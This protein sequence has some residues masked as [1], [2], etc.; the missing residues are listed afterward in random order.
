[1]DLQVS[2]TRSRLAIVHARCQ[3]GFTL[4]ELAVSTA[5]AAV[6]IGVAA[7]LATATLGQSGGGAGGQ[8]S[9]V[10]STFSRE[11]IDLAIRG[12]YL[13]NLRLPCVDQTGDGLENCDAASAA[14][15]LPHRTLGLNP[16]PQSTWRV[17]I[18]YGVYRNAPTADLAESGNRYALR[19]LRYGAACGAATPAGACTVGE[20]V[21]IA[22]GVSF[23][24]QTDSTN[25]MRDVCERLGVAAAAAQNDGLLHVAYPDG[26]KAPQAYVFAI[27]RTPEIKT[28]STALETRHGSES[29]VR[30][31]SELAPTDANQDDVYYGKSFNELYQ[32]FDC[33]GKT[34]GTESTLRATEVMIASEFIAQIR[35]QNA[36]YMLES[37]DSQVDQAIQDTAFA[38]IGVL[39]AT[40]DLVIAIAEATTANPVAIAGAV[41]AGIELANAIAG[42]ALAA[43]AITDAQDWR[44]DV[45]VRVTAARAALQAAGVAM[46]ESR[47][48]ADEI[49]NRGGM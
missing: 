36:N 4:V 2:E 1:M 21:T 45:T 16:P 47:T 24:E 6:V 35:V 22:A 32:D 19:P 3:R 48:F 31:L 11:T 26:A 30:F 43:L 23:R 9:G 13:A 5:V 14:G 49:A 17:P 33:I 39:T 20:A 7:S 42:V 27:S 12:F 29:A 41:T 28:G 18:A 8:E 40:A 37:A 25:N 34:V 10:G 15:Y 38:A 46:E 44:A